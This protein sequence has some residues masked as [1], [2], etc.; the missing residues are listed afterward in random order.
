[1]GAIEIRKDI[2]FA[3]CGGQPF[4][5]VLYRPTGVGPHPVLVAVHGGGWR[6]G[7][8]DT[9][10]VLGAWLAERGYALFAATYRFAAP[11]KPS[12]PHA[13]HD[14]RAAV[15]NVRG[16]AGELGIDP[17]RIGLMGDSAG[18]NLAALVA[19]AGDLPEF[20]QGN[21][22][23]AHGEQS[24]KV[25]ALVGVFGVY[26]L[27][28]QWRHDQL[29]RPLDQISELFVG[30]SLTEDRKP[31]FEAS[32]LS[33]VSTHRNDTAVMLAWGTDDDVVDPQTQS[34]VMLEALKQAKHY[35][36]TVII[37]GAPHFWVS[38]P[39]DEPGSYNGFFAPRLLRFLQEQL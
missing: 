33:Y 31:Y 36:R 38:E 20:A 30:C 26:D 22:G 1:M 7:S 18:G 25:K 9:Y 24:T 35:V 14:V 16:R 10:A 13:F 28:A 11:G 32:P 8:P 23:Q 17:S 15:Q 34:M 39:L 21:A 12:W 37:P 5:G 19:L 4:K 6:R 2:A 29:G 27:V 3:G